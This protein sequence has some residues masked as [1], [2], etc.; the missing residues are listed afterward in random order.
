MLPEQLDQLAVADV[1]RVDLDAEP[2]RRTPPARPTE[3]C[4]VISSPSASDS[5][6]YIV[7]CA[8][9]PPR[10]YSVAVGQRDDRRAEHVAAAAV[11]TSSWVSAATEL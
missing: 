4:G 10:S 6:P 2:A 11:C 9:S 7:S 8:H 1:R 5:E 3:V